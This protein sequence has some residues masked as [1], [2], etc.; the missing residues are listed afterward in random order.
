MERHAGI[1]MRANECGEPLL[2]DIKI[3]FVFVL[4]VFGKA[5]VTAYELAG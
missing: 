5:V 3:P 1:G 4:S 2:R